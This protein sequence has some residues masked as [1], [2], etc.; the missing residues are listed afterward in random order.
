VNLWPGV[1]QSS[2]QNTIATTKIQKALRC[3]H[4]TPRHSQQQVDLF[5][6]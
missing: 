5:G 1:E 6:G 3:T 4:R 2:T